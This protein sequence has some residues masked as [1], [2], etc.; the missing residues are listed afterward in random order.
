MPRRHQLTLLLCVPAA[1]IGCESMQTTQSGA[2]DTEKAQS[3]PAKPGAKDK[4]L[5]SVLER[6]AFRTLKSGNPRTAASMYRRV[7]EME[8]KRRSA[9]IGLADALVILG[10][11]GNA[12]SIYRMA[13][14]ADPGDSTVRGKLGRTLLSLNK[15]REALGLISQSASGRQ[16]ADILNNIG[17]AYLLMQDHAKAQ[18][19]FQ[20]AYS[21]RPENLGLRNNLAV[22][23]AMVGDSGKALRIFEQPGGAE[24]SQPH[25]RR[26][27]A[28]VRAMD[29]GR[30]IIDGAQLALFAFGSDTG[31]FV[32]AGVRAGDVGAAPATPRT[33]MAAARSATPERAASRPGAIA[34]RVQVP[35][36]AGQTR[37]LAQTDV[38]TQ[39]LAPPPADPPPMTA[40]P[41]APPR[42]SRPNIKPA[43]SDPPLPVAA[44][45]KMVKKMAHSAAKS[46]QFRVQ[47]GAFRNQRNARAAGNRVLKAAS[48][49]V[50]R[51][52]LALAES[53]DGGT[54]FRLQTEATT[55]RA[56]ADALCA[57]LKARSIG[58]FVVTASKG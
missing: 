20:R 23:F 22:S 11:H 41:M 30:R 38:Q 1:L 51:I 2:S 6:V 35:P 53:S 37:Q 43:A 12:A 26:N 18:Q 19:Y 7:L 58:C 52:V 25:F 14:A 21:S 54:I 42:S 4:N 24:V 33:R 46:G 28:L 47:L 3:A 48:G 56:E 40:Q 45:A 31:P 36:R 49:L 16:T 15:P 13:L 50:E 17:V 29:K 39:A 57:K 5:P 32:V 10:E 27:L 9:Q 34:N 44:P 8:P 55:T